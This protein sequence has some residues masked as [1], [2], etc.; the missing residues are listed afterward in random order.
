MLYR[1][2]IALGSDIGSDTRWSYHGQFH[3]Q[4]PW[5][6]PSRIPPEHGYQPHRSNMVAGQHCTMPNHNLQGN[7]GVVLDCNN[8]ISGVRSLPPYLYALVGE[9]N[10]LPGTQSWMWDI[11]LRGHLWHLAPDTHSRLSDICNT[12]NFL[13]FGSS[14]NLDN[15]GCTGNQGTLPVVATILFKS[16]KASFQKKPWENKQNRSFT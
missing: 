15:S 10:P 5:F 16:T 7:E 8:N 4:S 1:C 9:P 3:D 14:S 12:F 2:N 11:S 13:V 6:L